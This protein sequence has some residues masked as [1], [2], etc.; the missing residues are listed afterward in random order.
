IGEYAFQG[1]TGLTSITFNSATTVIG[2]Q[3]NTIPEAAKII[4]YD[5]STAKEYAEYYDRD[6]ES[7]GSVTLQSIAITN[8]AAKLSYTVGEAL[9]IT[10]LVVTGTYSDN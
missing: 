3:A 9:D 8:P 5:P 10:G 6:F 7:L 1:C 2:D 4:G